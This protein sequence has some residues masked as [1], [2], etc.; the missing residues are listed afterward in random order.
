MSIEGWYYLHVN[1]S[2]IYKRNLPGIAADIRE[3]SFAKA[4]WPF[5]STDRAGAWRI[6]VEGLSLGANMERVKELAALWGCNDK[7]A[8]H[9]A[10]PLGVTLSLD[11]DA[12]CA[13]Q[14]NFID[15]QE[16]MVGFGDTCLEA[17]ADLCKTL[18]F[19]GGKMWNHT[20]E[21]LC[22][23]CYKKQEEKQCK[24]TL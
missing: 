21:S 1:G 14:P 7:D 24:T 16:S 3:S 5:D 12:M 6:V 22:K 13:M 15:L 18:G 17:L 10:T 11:G 19:K 8:E 23:N 4:L 9:Y 20:F 2:L